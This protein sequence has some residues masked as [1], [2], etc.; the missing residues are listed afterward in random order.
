MY[1]VLEAG[2]EDE[3]KKSLIR[4]LKFLGLC[5]TIIIDAKKGTYNAASPDELALANAAK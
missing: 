3:D 2:D 4:C 1:D 5:H